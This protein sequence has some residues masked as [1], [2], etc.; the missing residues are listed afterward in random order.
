MKRLNLV[1]ITLSAF[2]LFT[3]STHLSAGVEV[4]TP[5]DADKSA[6]AE[7]LITRFKT[8]HQNHDLDALMNLVFWKDVTPQTKESVRKSFKELLGQRIKNIYIGPVPT[9]QMTEYTLGSVRYK[10]NLKPSGLLQIYVSTANDGVTLTS[11][12]VGV[13]GDKYV[14]ATAAPMK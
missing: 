8:A 10:I 5:K 12:V 14:I 11:Y 1:I 4:E 2:L 7:L 9:D 3:V 6:Q 13:H